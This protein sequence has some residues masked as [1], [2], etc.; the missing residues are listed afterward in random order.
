MLGSFNF[1][2]KKLSSLKP[3]SVLDTCFTSHNS[4]YDYHIPRAV[5]SK[6]TN[7]IPHGGGGVHSRYNKG[8]FPW[9]G[10]AGRM[11][12]QMQEM[13]SHL[14]GGERNSDERAGL[15]INEINARPLE[16]LWEDEREWGPQRK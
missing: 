15:Q 3:S 10:V 4:G 5:G 9:R 1:V 14:E 6:V 11:F 13:W 16:S 2:S 7:S 8:S 12:P